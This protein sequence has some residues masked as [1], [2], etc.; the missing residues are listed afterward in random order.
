MGTNCVTYDFSAIERHWQEKWARDRTF[1]AMEDFGKKKYYVLDM[2]P[3][4]S[5]AGLHIGHPEGYTAS[6]IIARYKRACGYNVLHPMGWDAFGLP[7]EQHA[8]KTGMSPAINTTNN[9]DVFRKQIQSFGFAIDWDREVNTT[10]PNYFRWTQWIFLQLFKHGLA[11]VDEKPVW[12][13][14]E[15]KSVLA[16]E[17]VINGVSERGEYPVERKNLRQWVL[18]ITKYADRLL[19][20]L[21]DVDWPESTKRQQVAWIGKSTGAHVTFK[22]ENHSA[23]VAIYTTRPDT[24]YGATFV[25]LAP[26]HEL[27]S[28][29]VSDGQRAAVEAYIERAKSKSDLERTDLAKSKTGVFTGAH[30]INPVN[31]EPLPI[32]IADY[33]LR[34][35]GTGAIMAV[36][37]HDD[38]DYEFAKKYGIEIRQ[39]IR[40]ENSSELPFCGD[41]KLV[42]SGEFTGLDS[43]QAKE[44]IIDK[45]SRLRSGSRAVNY[46]LRDWLFSRQRYWGEP[47]PVVWVEKPDYDFMLQQDDFYFKE[48]LPENEISYTSEGLTFCA[49]PLTPKELPLA[50]PKVDSY[51]PSDNGESPLAK[52]KSWTNIYINPISG[53]I[54]PVREF[55]AGTPGTWVR[56]RRETNTMPQWAGSCWY[57]LRYMSP[58]HSSALVEEHSEKYWQQ[59]D[60]YIGGAEHAVLHLLYARFWHKFLYDIG[61]VST[62][63]PFKKLFHQ[64]IILG[65]DGTKMSKSRG[66]VVNPDDVI[67]RYGADALRLYEMFLGPLEAM[68]PWG[69]RGIEGVSRFLKKTWNFYIADGGEIKPFGDE[70]SQQVQDVSNET[71]GKVTQDIENLRFNTAISQMMICLNTFVKE[72]SV[73]RVHATQFLQILTPFAPHISEEIYSRLDGTVNSISLL[74]WPTYTGKSDREN[75]VKLAVQI[76]GKLRGECRVDRNTECDRIIEI[77]KKDDRLNK[78]LT[79]KTIVKTVFVPAKIINI[80]VE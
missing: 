57:Y 21:K 48:F 71:I 80:V 39:V 24:L 68:K 25:V 49:V 54:I 58:H 15:L 19:D 26:E 72:K 41:G 29:I 60:M 45:L 79:G 44:A 64:G 27:V 77:V 20:G 1:R 11:Y 32:W 28:T 36:P 42:N 3:Y 78:F 46:K 40:W 73:S 61:A 16:N 67:G 50:L 34:S 52:A 53:E 18:R 22:V 70:S 51:I 37:A 17:E 31:G 35:Y 43:K 7:A 59:P 30:A 63:E 65:E 33:V 76:N 47:I 4:P 75:A 6:D 23:S 74:P 10:D 13:C 14:S 56:G 9:V 69:T 5:G 66:N 8:I 55:A 62:P 38:R 12:W 2:F